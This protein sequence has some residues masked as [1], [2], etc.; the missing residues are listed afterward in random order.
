MRFV[1]PEEAALAFIGHKKFTKLFFR[2][3]FFVA[4][5]INKLASKVNTK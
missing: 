3:F 4:V 5:T 1:G 2:V